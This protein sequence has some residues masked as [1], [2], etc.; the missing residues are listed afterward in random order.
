MSSVRVSM[1]GA[2]RVTGAR[3]LRGTLQL[4][5]DLQIGQQALVWAALSDGPCLVSGLA[6]RADHTLLVAGLREMGVSIAETDA[7]FRIQGVGLRGLRAPRVALQ[8]GDSAST[9]DILSTL[10]ACQLFGTRI[11]A[12]GR[13]A[14]RSMRT[15][16]EPLRERGAAINGKRDD[17]G[18][19]Y[20]P[21]AVTPLLANE[22][23]ADAEIEIPDGDPRTKLALLISGLYARG[24]TAI[25][26][27]TLSP[28]HVERALVALGAP[29]ETMVSMAMLDTSDWEPHWQG[30]S[31]RVPGD[32]GLA[33]YVIAAAAA[34][35]GSDVTLLGVGV[36][37]TRAAFFDVLRHAG[38]KVNVIPKGDTAGDEP[39]ADVR[40]RHAGLRGVRVFGELAL[41]V[42]DELPAVALVAL[43]AS[44]RTSVR[45]VASVRLEKPDKLKA[46]SNC[47]RRFRCE[48]TDYEDGF[49]LEPSRPRAVALE[50]KDIAGAELAALFLGLAA[51]GETRIDQATQIESDYPGVVAALCSLG[52]QIEMEETS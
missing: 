13:A 43:G 20:A 5:G 17:Q 32:F 19:V 18:D 30:F 10:L 34:I 21:I 42:R 41:R 51:D 44:S 35:P 22:R 27:G 29:L 23:L 38:A 36:N 1:R 7:G 11:E 2:V 45:D 47:L 49:D 12:Y 39:L 16:V 31:W 46:L 26:E 37:R 52:A 15:V 40:V 33:A 50:V 24:I 6:P 8:A 4:P 28:D 3:P 14:L 25:S 48:C 9:L